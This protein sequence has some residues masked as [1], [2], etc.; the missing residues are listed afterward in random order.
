MLGKVALV[1]PAMLAKDTLMAASIGSL[2]KSASVIHQVRNHAAVGVELEE[3]TVSYE[4]V[5]RRMRKA[6]A[7]IS[8]HNSVRR[9]TQ[10]YGIDLF[11]GQATFIDPQTLE[12]NGEVL[13]FQ[14]C[15]LN[16]DPRPLLI[17]LPVPYCTPAA[18]LEMATLPAS[19]TI[20]GQDKT[21]CELAQ[22]FCQDWHRS[23]YAGLGAITRTCA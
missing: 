2:L 8:Y 3:F 6:R 4:T 10:K 12:I 22:T 9:L 16:P 1:E 7:A 11:F 19:L 5:A 21:A 18:L 14:H 13:H 20:V 15:C 17:D 23:D